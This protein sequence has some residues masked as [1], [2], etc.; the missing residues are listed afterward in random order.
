M[1]ARHTSTTARCYDQTRVLTEGR[2]ELRDGRLERRDGRLVRVRVSEGH[3]HLAGTHRL[4]LHTFL[5]GCCCGSSRCRG[6]RRRHR[7]WRQLRRFERRRQSHILSAGQ[8]QRGGDRQQY[9]DEY[10]SK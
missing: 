5:L 1:D 2:E 3:V 8:R 7:R 4:L 10:S 6:G 9:A